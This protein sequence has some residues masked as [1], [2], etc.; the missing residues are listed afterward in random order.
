MKPALLL[1]VAWVVL[2]SCPVARAQKAP[3]ARYLDVLPPDPK[4]FDWW[5]LG[6]EG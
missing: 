2:T 3:R 6:P 4:L 1:G 5:H